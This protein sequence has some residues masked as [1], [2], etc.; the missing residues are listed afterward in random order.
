MRKVTS[1][2]AGKSKNV[3]RIIQYPSPYARIAE[4]TGKILGTIEKKNDNK[5]KKTH[6]IVI[7]RHIFLFSM[8]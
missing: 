8:E 3:Y 7:M 6:R 2:K 4:K 1:T 5:I